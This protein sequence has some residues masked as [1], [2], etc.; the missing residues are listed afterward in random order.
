M[1]STLFLLSGSAS[2]IAS[3]NKLDLDNCEIIKIDEKELSKPLKMITLL[4]K[5]RSSK[6]YFGTIDISFQ[7]FQ[8]FIKIYFFLSFAFN[9][10][11]NDELGNNNKFNL[12]IFFFI[13]I[14]LLFLELFYSIYLVVFY[15]IKILWLKWKYTRS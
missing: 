11:I 10:S 3:A 2:R 7:R 6:I 14:P 13:E 4:K 9:G 8:T 5:H 12:L 1:K 15:H